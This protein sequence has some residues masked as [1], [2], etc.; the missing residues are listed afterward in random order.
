LIA[1][2]LSTAMKADR[3]VVIEGGEVVETGTHDALVASG[4]RYADM[5]AMWIS[6]TEGETAASHS[7]AY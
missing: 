1:H 2:R 7:G 6:Q 4:G 3:I 5:Y